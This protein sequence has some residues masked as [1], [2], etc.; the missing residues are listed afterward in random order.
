MYGPLT[1]GSVFFI[2]KANN[3][4]ISKSQQKN[5][6]NG[7]IW[8][9]GIS[10][11]LAEHVQR[12]VGFVNIHS[13]L[14]KNVAFSLCACKDNAAYIIFIMWNS[15]SGP[16][17]S[18]VVKK[19][20]GGTRCALGGQPVAGVHREPPVELFSQG[21]PIAICFLTISVS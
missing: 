20:F 4:F 15:I 13:S 5:D 11:S 1:S 17:P 12:C 6:R 16:L 8:Q 9:R 10:E 2:F 7:G 3:Q 14:H 21:F 19:S 18:K